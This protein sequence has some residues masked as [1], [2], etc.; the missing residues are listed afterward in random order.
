MTHQRITE[1]G[2]L[3]C[4]CGCI[5]IALGVGL[6]FIHRLAWGAILTGFVG[7]LAGAVL[8]AMLGWSLVGLR[9]FARRDERRAQKRREEQ[10]R[11]ETELRAMRDVAERGY[12]W[13]TPTLCP[14]CGK[15]QPTGRTKCSECGGA[16]VT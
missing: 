12:S 16:L 2:F 1:T 4:G 10:A 6:G 11:R 13:E 3:A 9:W 5:G 7:M 8:G 15:A 14:D